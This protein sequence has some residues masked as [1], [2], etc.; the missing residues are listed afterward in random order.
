MYNYQNQV[1]AINT[2]IS[3]A[4]NA[5]SVS[6]V[7]A[8]DFIYVADLNNNGQD[9][10]TGE[11]VYRVDNII[12]NEAFTKVQVVK[13]YDNTSDCS[14][15]TYEVHIAQANITLMHVLNG[16]DLCG[17]CQGDNTS[18]QDECGIPNGTTQDIDCNGECF[19]TAITDDCGI[20]TGGSTNLEFNQ[21][22]DCAGECFGT[23]EL[24]DCDECNGENSSW[25]AREFV[26]E[27]LLKIVSEN[28]WDAQLDCSGVCEGDDTSCDDECGVPNGDN[29]TCS[30]CTNI[31]ALN[32][33]PEAIVDDGTCEYY[34]NTHWFVLLMDRM[35]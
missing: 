26:L 24:D 14:I 5:F 18:C 1:I 6:E 28:E 35:N 25:T 21:Y 27:M 12:N 15:E 4:N 16:N 8:E 32:Y 30:G 20:C 3:D 11:G 2:P 9:W 7:L 17:V 23:A 22:M 29:S 19:G 31:V 34:S 13:S 10:N 33:D